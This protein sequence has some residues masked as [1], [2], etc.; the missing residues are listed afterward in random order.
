V[1]DSNRKLIFWA[2]VA[3]VA[4]QVLAGGK[5]VVN[6]VPVNV[7]A[8]TYVYEKDETAVPSPVM[9]ALNTLNKQGIVATLFEEDTTDGTG[10]TPEQAKVPLAA[11]KAAGLP[12]LVVTA[13]EKV[14]RTVKD[15]KTAE[16]VLEAAKP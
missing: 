15:P 4:W 9:A 14:V 13:G 10:D 12:A 11:A 8:A 3:F 6:P 16:A 1:S 2:I 5:H 7:T